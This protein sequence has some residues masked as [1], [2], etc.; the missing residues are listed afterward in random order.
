MME[1]Y[2][3]KNSKHILQMEFS[4]EKNYMSSSIPL[5]H[6]ILSKELSSLDC[7][8]EVENVKEHIPMKEG[9]GR[10]M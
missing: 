1:N 9:G 7:V 6:I 3:L 8:N 5:I 4:V 2:P 10:K